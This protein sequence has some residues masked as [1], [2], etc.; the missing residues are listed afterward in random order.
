MKIPT[1]LLASLA[2]ALPGAGCAAPGSALTQVVVEGEVIG[3]DGG[4]LPGTRVHLLLPAR[5]GLRGLDALYGKPGDYGHDDQM[6]SVT[7]DA[8]GRFR[9]EFEPV[10][11]SIMFWLIPPLGASFQGPPDPRLGVRVEG[12]EEVNLIRISGSGVEVR[13]YRLPER[14]P[15]DGPPAFRITGSAEAV[16]QPVEG[17]R[18]H[19]RLE[20]GGKP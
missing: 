2:L 15:L 3:E 12:V 17:H 5:Y 14:T 4:P 16:E 18:V 7:A 19:L 11:Y 9:V 6:R 8:D 10:T 20:R 13:T 1:A